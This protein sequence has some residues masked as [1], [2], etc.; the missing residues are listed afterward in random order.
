MNINSLNSPNGTFDWETQNPGELQA[1]QARQLH[2]DDVAVYQM[3]ILASDES[4]LHAAKS[5]GEHL[6]TS[7]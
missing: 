7:T 2:P 4:F 3:A 5:Y 1:L 6:F